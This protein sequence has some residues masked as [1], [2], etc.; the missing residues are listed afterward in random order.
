VVDVVPL[1]DCVASKTDLFFVC[2]GG[3]LGPH[4]F[5][6]GAA[7]REKL[8]DY[9]GLIE[10]CKRLTRGVRVGDERR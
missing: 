10:V 6:A 8:A 1:S 4:F 5:F 3:S 9:Q 7:V 2:G